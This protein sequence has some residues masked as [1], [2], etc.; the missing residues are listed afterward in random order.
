MNGLKLIEDGKLSGVHITSD[1][2]L[3]AD[4]NCARTGIQEYSSREFGLDSNQIIRVWRPEEEVFSESSMATYAG[5]P[6]T[7]D[8]PDEPVNASNW[9]K[10]TVGS[11]GNKI[12]RSGDYVN[13]PLILMDGDVIKKV[14]DGKRELSMGYLM[15]I[16]LTPGMTPDGEPYDAIQRNL[17]MNHIA[18]VDKGRAGS[19]VRIGDSWL[20]DRKPN[21]EKPTMTLKNIVVDGL[22]VETTD[23]AEKAIVKLQGQVQDANAALE[24]ATAAHD[25]AIATAAAEHDT[26]MSTAKA[27][28]DTE[29]ATRDTKIAELEKQVVTGEALDALVADRE[30]LVA[31]VK[32]F[33]K[34]ADLTGKSTLEMKAMAV[35]AA[36]ASEFTKGQNETYINVAFDML[37][38]PEVKEDA[39]RAAVAT[40]PTGDK[41]VNDNGH[42][43]YVANLENAW[44]GNAGDKA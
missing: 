20:P 33:T 15:D 14:Q 34:D 11:I 31:K 23:A 6:A 26:A 3:A 19:A 27:T 25:T 13:V 12:V 41:S 16:E 30:A 28:H 42:S 10:L 44:K 39:F 22:T 18:L 9:K 2:Y 1:G 7:D 43:K 5:K 37:K 40:L 8:H 24:T 21:V 32:A 36:H 29:L 38:V 35:D 17:K 4:V